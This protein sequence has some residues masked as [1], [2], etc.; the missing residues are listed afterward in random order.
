MIVFTYSFYANQDS[1][2][3]VEIK[4]NNL[5]SF[6]A[7]NNTLYSKLSKKEKDVFM[8]IGKNLIFSPEK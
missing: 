3:N 6:I 1:F 5:E 7:K 8:N 4:Q 2:N